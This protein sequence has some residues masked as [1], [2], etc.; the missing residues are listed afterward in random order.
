MDFKESDRF[1]AI[2]ERA[3]GGPDPHDILILT[4]DIHTGRLSSAEIVG[5]RGPDLRARRLA[6]LARHAVPAAVGPQAVRA[7]G[8]ADR[9]TAARG[10]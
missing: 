4:G 2:F 10:R 9:S 3:L 6:R 1:G 8:Q 5:L 7:A